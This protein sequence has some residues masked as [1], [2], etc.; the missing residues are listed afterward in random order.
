[1]NKNFKVFQIYGLTGL[2]FVGI[3]MTCLFCGFVLFPVWIIMVSWNSMI[4]GM[5]GVP[6]INYYQA[7]LLWIFAILC[8]YLFLKNSIKIKVYKSDAPDEELDDEDMVGFIENESDEV[9]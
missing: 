3:I 8:F 9:N 7:S 5:Y 2:L 4:T 6:F 1:M